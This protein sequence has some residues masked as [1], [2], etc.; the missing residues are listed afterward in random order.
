MGSARVKRFKLVGDAQAQEVAVRLMSRLR[1]DGE[2]WVWTG[3]RLP[4]GYGLMGINGRSERVHVVVMFLRHGAEALAAETVNHL[5]FNRACCNPE[6]L[7]FASVRENNLHGNG[8]SGLHAA[9]THCPH[10]HEY[11]P[12]NISWWRGR[13]DCLKCKRNSARGRRERARAARERCQDGG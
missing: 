4:K 10:G 11:S 8:T 6:H 1:V 3:C 9:K 2:C 13:R 7:Q 5:C 12:E